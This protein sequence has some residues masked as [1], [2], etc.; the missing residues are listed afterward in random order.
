MRIALTSLAAVALIAIVIGGGGLARAEFETAA[1][2]VV[3]IDAASGAVLYEKNADSAF[4]PASMSKLMTL[5][6]LF[7]AL[8][9]KKVAL[10]SDLAVSE[11]AWRTGGAPSG[12]SA[13]F[14][15]L[16]TRVKLSDVLQGII[17]QSANDGCIIV[18]EALAGSEEAFAAEMTTQARAIGLENAT[19]GNAT[20]LPHPKQRM[21]A[22]ELAILARHLVLEYPEHYQ[23]FSQKLF[24]Y[25]RYKFFN[26]NPLLN[27]GIGADGFVPGFVEELGYGLVGSAVKDGRR[28]IVVVNGLDSNEDRV[29][30]SKKLFDWGFRSFKE[31]AIFEPGEV[32]GAA[33]V[34]G[35]SSYSVSLVGHGPIRI[36][37]PRSAS[38]NRL[39]ASIEYLW[40]LK[41]PI[42]KG[43]RVA[44]LRVEHAE[45]GVNEVPLYAAEG[46][47]PS[48]V[49][50]R[51]IDSLL[52]KAVSWVP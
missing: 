39:K 27:Q 45:A 37:V 38:K 52:I 40:P 34:W 20:G 51:G 44:V 19:F 15:S 32:I 33:R 13:M 46:V 12:T 28:L 7:K 5:A 21:S 18:A 42:S 35:G 48:G 10:D 24:E 50:A 31:V 17:V 16:G 4:P 41:A 22:R 30:E 47:A 26:R 2:E 11:H 8:R 1:R 25:K 9:E 23:H 43:D 6:V 29:R 14:A 3:L 36:L 49:I